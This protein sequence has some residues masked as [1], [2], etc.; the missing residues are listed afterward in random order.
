MPSS[1][2][3][4]L[5]FVVDPRLSA[6]Q[7][8]VFWRA[9]VL[10]TVVPL[11]PSP[12]SFTGA[13]AID[14]AELGEVKERAGPDGRHVII[15]TD[16]GEL[17]VW[18][19]DD[20]LEQPLVLALPLDDDLPIRVPAALRL[21]ARIVRLR[22]N[23]GTSPLALTRQRHD[24]LMLMLRALDGHLPDASYREI[25]QVLFGARRLEH[26]PWKTS[27][28][29]DMTIRLVKGGYALMQAGYRELLRGR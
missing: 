22:G 16:S 5:P 13:R 23:P 3:G 24:R 28:L 9:N 18:V 12:T 26:E 7:A 19:L 27:S 11:A 4:G 8:T 6:D 29:R 20:Q 15:R 1:G 21:W 17:R 25:A 14:F 10:P 2:V